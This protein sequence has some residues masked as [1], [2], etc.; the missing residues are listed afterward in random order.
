MGVS[1]SKKDWTSLKNY[2]IINALKVGK[3]C[4]KYPACQFNQVCFQNQVLNQLKSVRN[5]LKHI[6]LY[7]REGN[8]LVQELYKQE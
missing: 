8:F 3:L 5:R 1:D 4:S 2:G 7:Q 6:Y